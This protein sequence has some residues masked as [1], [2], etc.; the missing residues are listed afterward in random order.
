MKNHL[1]MKK[2]TTKLL[3]LMLSLAM[4]MMSLA[5]CGSSG[6]ESAE[7]EAAQS[8]VGGF[9]MTRDRQTDE[10]P[11]WHEPGAPAET[12]EEAP[13]QPEEAPAQEQADA[14]PEGEDTP[15][16]SRASLPDRRRRSRRS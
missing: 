8:E 14:A 11:A 4:A 10:F 7:P 13:A 2:T 3:V 15:R 12:Q 16:H 5:A 6:S 9:R 1:S